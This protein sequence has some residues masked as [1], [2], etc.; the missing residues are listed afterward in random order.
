MSVSNPAFTQIASQSGAQ[1]RAAWLRVLEQLAH[2]VLSA[3]SEGRLKQTMPVESHF[4]RENRSQYSH[5]EAIARLL[6]G[7][8]PWLELGPDESEEGRLRANYSRLARSA[9]RHATD[10]ASSDYLNF[11]QGKQPL[12]EMGLLAQAI[13]RAPTELWSK[14]EPEVQNNVVAALQNARNIRPAF[15]NWLLFG[16]TVEAAFYAIG[17]PYDPMRLDYALRQMEQWYIGDGH[18]S[19]GPGFH[20]DYYN[21]LVIHP[22]LV[23]I[24]RTMASSPE[25]AVWQEPIQTRAKRYAAILERSISPEGTF[26]PIGRSLAYRFGA[27]QG[28]G[29]AAL[30]GY[31]PEELTPGGVRAAMTAVITRMAN[32]P[33]TFDA[34]GWLRIGFCGQQP[35][36][37]EDYV[38]TGSL[39]L[40]AVGLLPLGLPANHDFW[41]LPAQP[42]TARRLWNGE[43]LPADCSLENALK[44]GHSGTEAPVAVRILRKLKRLVTPAKK[45]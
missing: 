12:V 25:W 8:A 33:G 2:P 21:S 10:P 26:P 44:E 41:T 37:G 35:D 1:D 36:I 29:Q 42:W 43:N 19:D 3:L 27:L 11:T 30:L 7:I 45:T 31:L 16:A 4:K 14:L 34:N 17:R 28:L 18:Y 39:Y 23:D 32:A 13:L 5:L 24:T 38:S 6:A 40:C 9:L 15:N 22:M 20:W